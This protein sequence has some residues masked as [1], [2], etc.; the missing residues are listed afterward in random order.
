MTNTKMKIYL[1]CGIL[2]AILIA[3]VVDW[4]PISFHIKAIALIGSYVIFTIYVLCCLHKVS[5]E[6]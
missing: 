6:A 3:I 1:L 4:I 2:A 5:Y